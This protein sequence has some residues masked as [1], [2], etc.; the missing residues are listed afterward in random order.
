MRCF[1]CTPRVPI[2]FEGYGQF[3]T[4]RLVPHSVIVV[5]SAW[6]EYVEM[7]CRALCLNGARRVH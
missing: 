1:A 4:L 6:A 5:W 2:V 3:V 7:R